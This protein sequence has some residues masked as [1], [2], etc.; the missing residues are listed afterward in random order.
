V[1]VLI[2]VC[3][4]LWDSNEKSFEF[5]QCYTEEWAERL[6]DGLER[7]LTVPFKMALFVDYE[8][9]LNRPIEQHLLERRPID[10]GSC[11]E[12]Y[13]LPGPK[14]VMGLD[15]VIT[16][17][18][19]HL[20]KWAIAG[21]A[22]LLPRDPYAPHQA[23]NGVAICPASLDLWSGWDGENDMDWCRSFPHE[24]VSNVFPGD[25]VS[26]KGHVRDRGIENAKIVYFH[27]AP[28]M[29]ELPGIAWVDEHWGAP[30]L[31]KSNTL[32]SSTMT[33]RRYS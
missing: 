31:N 16:G 24:M 29:H 30:V 6:Y 15:T 17:N 27:G 22:F 26:Y 10:Y 2:T 12:P 1:A 11:I 28:K 8:R 4:M 13:K 20:A 18:I 25:V 14:I 3:A 23:C 5:S 19:D 21:N 7:N 9:E 32:K 33:R